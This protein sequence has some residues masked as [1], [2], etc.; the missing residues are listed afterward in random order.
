VGVGAEGIAPAYWDIARNYGAS[1]WATFAHIVFFG[2][3]LT[4]GSICA[5]ALPTGQRRTVKR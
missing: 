5:V 3:L 1:A 4:N 2:A